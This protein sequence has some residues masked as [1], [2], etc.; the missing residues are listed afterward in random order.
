VWLK[1]LSQAILFENRSEHLILNFWIRLFVLIEEPELAARSIVSICQT[2]TNITPQSHSFLWWKVTQEADWSCKND[3]ITLERVYTSLNLL[4]LLPHF[5][6]INP[7]TFKNVL[8]S[9]VWDLGNL[10]FLAQSAILLADLVNSIL[11]LLQFF[12]FSFDEFFRVVDTKW[13]GVD[14]WFDFSD[15]CELLLHCVSHVKLSV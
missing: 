13:I 5:V 6:A 3:A 10:N 9:H 11:I 14:A 8:R 12:F 7:H 1:Y 15:L 4:Q 2:V